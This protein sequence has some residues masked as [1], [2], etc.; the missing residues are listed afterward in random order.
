M[1]Q[2]YTIDLTVM[3]KEILKLMVRCG[4]D[5]LLPWLLLLLF[6]HHFV[7]L[8]LMHLDQT[9]PAYLF[10]ALMLWIFFIFAWYKVYWSLLDL[11]GYF[12]SRTKRH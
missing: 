7:N 9:S 5:V 8:D 3:I 12:L 10:S 11:I 6:V 2:T 1:V 4:R